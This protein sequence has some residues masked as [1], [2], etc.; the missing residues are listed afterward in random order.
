MRGP[1]ADQE[2]RLFYDFR[3]EATPARISREIDATETMIER[4]G[5][6]FALEPKQLAGDVAYGRA[7]M[8]GWPVT[9]LSTAS[10]TS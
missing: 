9:T 5:E 10:A 3:L 7:Q 8:L 6:R 4:V 2:D 1:P